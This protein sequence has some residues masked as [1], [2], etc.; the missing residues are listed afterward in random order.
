MIADVRNG[1]QLKIPDSQP[2]TT[3]VAGWSRMSNAVVDRIPEIGLPAFAVFAVLAKH[4][5]A[6]GVA[7]PSIARLVKATGLS[8]RTVRRGLQ[9]LKD[10][11]LVDW[12][13]RL[14]AN[15]VST[16]NRYQLAPSILPACQ[17]GTGAPVGSACEG[18]R[19]AGVG[20]PTCEGEGGKN[21]R[22][23]LAPE[24]H[25]LDPIKNKTQGNKARG[26]TAAVEI[27]EELAGDEFKA[28]WGKWLAY[29]RAR[30]LTCTPATL[31]GQL[32]KLA[33]RGLVGAVGEIDASITNGWQSVCYSNGGSKNGNGKPRVGPGQRHAAERQ[34]DD[35]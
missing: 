8:Q 10:A 22:G 6:D 17:G 13:P 7:W 16:S 11:D 31:Q 19:P 30:K 28:A 26:R 29:R 2:T 35:F 5:N 34:R 14:G 3:A 18:S 4:A 25:E 15:G 24:H 23:T 20:L 9:A 27:P 12:T 32:A 33:A 21:D 1:S